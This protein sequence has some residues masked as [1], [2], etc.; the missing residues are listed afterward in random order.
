MQVS[1]KMENERRHDSE[2]ILEAEWD[3]GVSEVRVQDQDGVRRNGNGKEHDAVS[4]ANLGLRSL[5][6]GIRQL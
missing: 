6:L 2:I 3:K 1:S 5:E 4:Y